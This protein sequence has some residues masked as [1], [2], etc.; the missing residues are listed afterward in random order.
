MW[1]VIVFSYGELDEF[2]R[3]NSALRHKLLATLSRPAVR[4][5]LARHHARTPASA[6]TIPAA[7]PASSSFG[8]DASS[9]ESFYRT[10]YRPDR[11]ALLSP[12]K[13]ALMF[14]T[15][16]PGTANG[17]SAAANKKR[18]TH[19]LV[20]RLRAEVDALKAESKEKTAAVYTSHSHVPLLLI[21]HF[22]S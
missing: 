8:S 17:S 2:G 13:K 11:N 19:S 20:A 6:A 4:S 3:E 15:N 12:T 22:S 1:D 9:M 5:L 14:P 7:T 18:F 10:R 16:K 21:A